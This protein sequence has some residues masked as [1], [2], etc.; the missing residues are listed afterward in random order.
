MMTKEVVAAREAFGV[1]T[2]RNMTVE[3]DLRCSLLHMLALMTKEV[4]RVEEPLTARAPVRPLLTAKMDLE[5][6]A[7]I[8]Q[9][10]FEYGM[11][12]DI[13]QFAV[14]IERLIAT[15]HITSEPVLTGRLPPLRSAL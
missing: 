7:R 13:L 10:K 3:G 5:V 6:A 14:A 15:L 9:C 4:L 8:V 12:E 1:G 2:S 11:Q